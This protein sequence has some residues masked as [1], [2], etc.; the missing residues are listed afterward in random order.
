MMEEYLRRAMTISRGDA[1][2]F[3]TRP[4]SAPCWPW[5]FIGMVIVLLPAIRKTREEVFQAED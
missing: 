3:L 4:L 5:P 2:T 1:T